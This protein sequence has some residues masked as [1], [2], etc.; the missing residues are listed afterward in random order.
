LIDDRNNLETRPFRRV[1]N[2]LLDSECT[3]SDLRQNDHP[4]RHRSGKINYNSTTAAGHYR[5]ATDPAA[6]PHGEQPTSEPARPKVRNLVVT[7]ASMAKLDAL[8][9]VFTT[10]A[11]RP[12]TLSPTS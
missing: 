3:L 7:A 11:W 6:G 1:A 5:R 12:P 10:G 9:K 8:E 4:P 2:Y